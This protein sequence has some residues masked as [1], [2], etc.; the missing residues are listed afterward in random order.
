MV[1]PRKVSSKSLPAPPRQISMALE[2]R[3]LQELTPL[4]RL[5]ALTHLANLLM[6][7]AGLAVEERNHEPR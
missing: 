3:W 7:A 5:R 2:S 6:L 1:Q 4:E